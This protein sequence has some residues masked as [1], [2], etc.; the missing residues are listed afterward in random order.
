MS[1]RLIQWATGN[2]GRVAL[3]AGLLDGET[4]W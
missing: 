4:L 2:L 3:E 1:D